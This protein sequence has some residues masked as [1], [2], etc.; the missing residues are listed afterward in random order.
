MLRREGPPKSTMQRHSASRA[1]GAHAKITSSACASLPGHLGCLPGF[2]SVSMQMAELPP[3][4]T[5]NGQHELPSGSHL[6]SASGAKCTRSRAT[7]KWRIE[8]RASHSLPAREARRHAY[9]RACASGVREERP[10]HRKKTTSHPTSSIQLSCSLPP[11]ARP[12]KAAR[13]LH[14]FR[15]HRQC[16]GMRSL[17]GRGVGTKISCL[18]QPAWLSLLL[19]STFYSECCNTSRTDTCE[20]PTVPGMASKRL[21]FAKVLEAPAGQEEGHG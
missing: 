13:R 18:V 20:G 1:P 8:Y 15:A 6:L 4:A 12:L 3:N 10:R 17:A 11:A 21:L 16:S 9:A 2:Q 19:A 14:L 5:S 7:H